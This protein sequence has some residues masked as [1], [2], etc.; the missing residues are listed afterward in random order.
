MKTSD[1]SVELGSSSP[2]VDVLSRSSSLF[3]GQEAHS[4]IRAAPDYYSS[5]ILLPVS[6]IMNDLRQ[7]LCTELNFRLPFC[8]NTNRSCSVNQPLFFK[9]NVFNITRELNFMLTHPHFRSHCRCHH[10]TQRKP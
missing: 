3:K 8:K 6:F 2:S 9:K 5:V 4:F 7:R 1:V 10:K